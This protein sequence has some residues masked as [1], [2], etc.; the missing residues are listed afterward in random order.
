MAEGG[1]GGGGIGKHICFIFLFNAVQT[2]REGNLFFQ[3]RLVGSAR[4]F[5][6]FSIN[7]RKIETTA[8]MG[9][10]DLWVIF[11]SAMAGEASV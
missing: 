7:L 2:A 10:S 1:L 3:V 4:E 11:L 8:R 9:I 5:N 6:T